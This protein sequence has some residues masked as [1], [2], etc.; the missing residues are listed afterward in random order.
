MAVHTGRRRSAL[1]YHPPIHLTDFVGDR[2]G[3]RPREHRRVLL[4]E[5]QRRPAGN[6]AARKPDHGCGRNRLVLLRANHHC[7]VQRCRP[8][9]DHGDDAERVA[10]QFPPSPKNPLSP[11]LIEKSGNQYVVVVPTVS[12]LTAGQVLSGPALATLQKAHGSGVVTGPVTSNGKLS[13]ARFA[14]NVAGNSYVYVQFAIP[15]HIDIASA[16]GSSAFNE[17]NVALYGPGAASPQNLLVT[18]TKQLPLTGSTA[19]TKVKVGASNWNLV[20]TAKAP[21][22]SGLASSGPLILLVLGLFIALIVMLTTETVQRRHRY[23]QALV[24]ERT[25]DLNASLQELKDTQDAL[26]QSERLTAVGEMASV[27]GHELRNP[28]AAVTNSL[29]IVRNDLGDVSPTT[30]KYL[31]LAERE[32]SKA[33]TLADDLTAFVRPREL[34]KTE[35]ELPDLVDEVMVATPHPDGVEVLVDVDPISV[36]GDRGQL[37]EVLTNLVTNAYQAMPEGGTLRLSAVERQ[38]SGD[39]RRRGHWPRCRPYGDG[40][41][42]RPLLHDQDQRH[43]TRPGHRAPPRRGPRRQDHSR[44]PGHRR[45]PGD[46][47]PPHCHGGGAGVNGVMLADILVVDDEEPV[48]SSVAEIC[49]PPATRCSRPRTDRSRSTCSSP[50]ASGDPPR[51]PD[52]AKERHRGPGGTGRPAQRHLDVRLPIRGRGPKECRGQGL[53]ASGEPVAPRRLLDEVPAMGRTEDRR[54]GPLGTASANPAKSSSWSTTTRSFR[55]TLVGVLAVEG[56]E[57]ITTG[58][59]DHTL[60]L[61]VAQKPSHVVVD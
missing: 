55:Q 41:G 7:G 23:A 17:L 14:T 22:V 27:I 60:E 52:A 53:L 48:R 18:T 1:E 20:A 56:I 25:A 32:T 28:L 39:D 38:F 33:A 37:A 50:A 30:E 40:S 29:F 34:K 5:A 9:E 4:P 2:G 19:H 10:A 61:V 24:Q 11:N 58:R 36:V 26:V 21:F 57:T 51:H 46:R 35:I 15:P 49:G 12:G 8:G 6:S 59:V 31:S 42:V 43:R 16:L 3:D 45:R 54:D 13:T 47:G 44:E